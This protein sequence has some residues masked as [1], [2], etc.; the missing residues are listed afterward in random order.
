M[1]FGAVAQVPD[2]W[3]RSVYLASSNNEYATDVAVDSTNGAV[4]TAGQGES[5]FNLLGGPW[6]LIWGN[7]PTGQD[8]YLFKTDLNGN[9]IWSIA[10]GGT[11]QDACTGVCVGPN[12]NVYVCGYFSGNSASFSG[13]NGGSETLT[14]VGGRDLFLLCYDSNGVLQWKVRAGASGDD[15]ATGVACNATQVFLTGSFKGQPVIAGSNTSTGLSTTAAHGFLAAF[16]ASDSSGLWRMDCA[17]SNDAQLNAV[18]T[19]GNDVYAIGQFSG[20]SCK[21]YNTAGEAG[22]GI[23]TA[24]G[25]TDNAA[26]IA[27]T[28]VGAFQWARAVSN[29]SGGDGTFSAQAIAVSDNGLCIGGS[30]HNGSIFPGNTVIN[31]AASPHDLAYV[32]LL[33]RATGN[34]RWVRTMYSPNGNAHQQAV[35]DIVMDRQGG[36]AVTG[37]FRENLLLP[38]GSTLTG[39]NNLQVY[40]AKF[41]AWGKCKWGL[42]ATGSGDD[43]PYGIAQDGNGHLYVAGIYSGSIAFNTT[44]GGGGSSQNLFLAWLTDLDFAV[45]ALHDPSTWTGFGP[46]CANS[47]TV[48]LN[49]RLVAQ[50]AGTGVSVFA[51]SGI[52]TSGSNGPAGALGQAAGGYAT[53]DDLNDQL[54]IGL[55]DTLPAGQDLVIRWQRSGSTGTAIMSVA[56]SLAG[57]SGFTDMGNVQTSTSGAWVLTSITMTAPTRYVRLIRTTG[58]TT[59]NVD[60]IYYDLGSDPDGIWSGTGVSGSTFDPSAVNGSAAITYTVNGRSTT[61]TIAVTALPGGGTFTG[62]TAAC[63]NTSSGTLTISGHS[64]SIVRW[65]YATDGSATY[66]MIAA[67]ASSITTPV[68]TQSTRY[69][70]LLSA[71]GCNA[72]SNTASVIV[73]DITAPVIVCPGNITAHTS[74]GSCGA[75]AVYALPAATD[76]CTASPVIAN[77]DPA[78]APGSTFPIGVTT[79][80][81]RATDAAGNVGNCSFTVT[82]ID[83]IAPSITCPA[84]ITVPA[85]AGTCSVEVNYAVP[86]VSDACNG[87]APNSIAQHTYLGTFRGHTYFRSWAAAA[88]ANANTA[89]AAIANGHL[90]ALNSADEEDWLNSV[91]L[92]QTGSYAPF[93]TGLNDAAVEGTFVWA[94]GDPVSYTHWAP[95]QP[96]NYGDADYAY[97]NFNNSPGWDDAPESTNFN[98]I[99]EIDALPALVPVRL[100]GPAS[101]SLLPIGVDTVTYQV[102]DPSGNTGSCSFRITVIDTLAPTIITCPSNIQVNTDANSCGA[103]VSYRTPTAA[104]D[105]SPVTVSRTAGPVSGS[106]FPL[107]TTTVTHRAT[108]AAGNSTACSFTVT[109]A[110]A[111]PPSINCPANITVN[112]QPGLC[113][114]VVN[115]TPPIGTDNCTGAATVRTSGP[116]SG[117]VFQLGTTTVTHRVTDAAGNSTACSFTVTVIDAQPPSIN[118]PADITVNAQP[119]LCGAV[120]N[121]TPPIGTDNCTGAVTVRTSGPVSGS[122]FSVGTTTITHRVTDAAGN[123]TACSFTVTVTDAQPPSI[124]CPADITVNAQPGLCGAVVNY[125]PPIGTDNCT[126]AVTVRTAGPASGS[127][128]PTGTTTITHRVTDATGLWSECSFTVTVNDNEPPTITCPADITVNAQPGLCGA[129]VNYTPPIGTDNCTGAVTVRTSGPESGGVFQLG[130]TTV[131]HRV[132]DAAGN[133]TACSFTVTVTDAQ[134]PSINCPADVTVNA[135]PGLCGAVVSYTPPIGTDNCTGAVT[136]RTAGPASGSLFPV[137]TTTITHRVTDAAGLWSECSFTVTVNDNEPPTIICPSDITVQAEPG[138]CSAHVSYTEPVGTDNCSGA[139]TARLAGPASGSLF[140]VGTTSITYEATDVTGNQATCSFTVSVID[141]QPPTITCPNDTTVNSDPSLCGRNVIY[142]TP[143]AADN[144]SITVTTRTAGPASGSAFPIGNT[145]VTYATTDAAGTAA[146]CSFIVHVIDDLA[147]SLTCPADIVTSNAPGQCG[148]IVHYPTPVGSDNCSGWTVARIAGPASGSLFPTGTTPVVHRV[149]DAAGNSTD[150]SFTVTVNDHEPPVIT[151]PSDTTIIAA[152]GNCGAAVNYALPNA[153]DACTGPVPVSVD[154]AVSSGSIFPIGTTEVVLHAVDQAGNGASCTFH[155]EVVA[156]PIALAYPATTVCQG[157]STLLPAT[158]TPANG[159]FSAEAGLVIDPH[160]GAIAAEQS[161]A[162]TYTVHYRTDG[163]CAAEALFELTVVAAP[164]PGTDGSAAFCVNDAIGVLLDH[165]QDNPDTNGTW[166]G[167]SP[168]VDG[169]FDPASMPAGTYVYTVAGRTPCPSASASVAVTLIDVHDAAFG[170]D[171]EDHCSAEGDLTP[172]VQEPG[173]LF[174]GSIGLDIDPWTGVVRTG[175]SSIGTHTVTY[176][177]DGP[178]GDAATYTLNIHAMPVADAGADRTVCGLSTRLSASGNGSWIVP[179]GL[180]LSDVNDA[181][182]NAEAIAPGTYLLRWVVTNGPCADTA[183]VSIRFAENAIADAGPDLEVCGLAAELH[184]AGAGTWSG[185]AGTVFVDANDPLTS[186][187]VPAQGVFTLTWTTGTGSCSASDTVDVRFHAPVDAQAGPDTAWCGLTA[188]L[189][190]IGNGSWSTDAAGAHIAD[191]T[192]PNTAMTVDAEGSYPLIWTIGNGRCTVRDTV[193]IVLSSPIVAHAGTAA[194]ICGYT[195]RLD[196]QGPGHWSLTTGADIADPSD[197]HSLVTIREEGAY[198]FEW[199]TVNGSCSSSDEVTIVFHAPVN[200]EAGVNQQVCGTSAVLAASGPGT[201][202]AP[203]GVQVAQPHDPTS[204][205]NADAPGTYALVWSAVNGTCSATDTVSITF[206]ASADASF[207]Y[208]ATL[209]CSAGDDPT[210]VAAEAGGTYSATPSGLVLDAAS[211]TIDVSTSAPGS[212]TVLHDIAGQCPASSSTSITISATADASWQ[213]PGPICASADPL[214]L[215]TLLTTGLPGGVWSGTG[216]HNGTFDPEGL[217][218]LI[219]ITYSTGDGAC[220]VSVQHTITVDAAPVANAGPD[221]AVCILSSRM[222]AVPDLGSG[223]WSGPADAVFADLHDPHS[224]VTVQ[225]TGIHM[226]TWAVEAGTCRSSDQVTVRFFDPTTPLWVHAGDDQDMD[227]RIH[228]DLQGEASPGATIQWSVIG[229][230]G[231]IDHSTSPATTVHGLALG[232]NFL[233]LSASIGNCATTSDTVR[234]HVNDV[235]IPQGFSPDGDGVNE[236]FAITGVAEFPGN[237]V[238][239]FD[240]WGKRVFHAVD[241]RNEWDG[242]GENGLLP[243]GTYFYL[244]ELTPE[245]SYQGYVIIKR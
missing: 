136:V 114:A 79:I 230:N 31:V 154:A 194:E 48:D 73:Q 244:V 171:G 91:I 142:A 192:D 225:D 92:A 75:R 224:L 103:V 77:V 128:F 84:D 202:S 100:S 5:L 121:Y 184:A 195:T 88:W 220:A 62:N 70:A 169:L 89:A 19:R 74:N 166:S 233:M 183:E 188:R 98:W 37:T 139:T 143:V 23:T 67:T 4:Y 1:P 56:G 129:V 86:V 82:V 205:V 34:T 135:Q 45:A 10:L 201:W 235:F 49:T 104:D 152:A 119:G 167:P 53:F 236:T 182:A 42:A 106:V 223:T 20:T 2:G 193:I 237:I 125:M 72:Y 11:G 227:I 21:F 94:N 231:V 140:P 179:P 32:A 159:H 63:P 102:T 134:P 203:A 158:A 69:R 221:A 46:V 112:A 190:A 198:V 111:R 51:S 170:F 240:R 124:N 18:C 9:P 3:D 108:D 127:L 226:F 109:V 59:F 155:I 83:S 138:Q 25:Q 160:T 168:V 218:G 99:V 35:K 27:M 105:C 186:V 209:F 137:G 161:R 50:R 66:A 122:L 242:H 207:R 151:C 187:S 199:T 118:C 239:V 78:Q 60:G 110:D 228:A 14:S 43:A 177:I 44:L 213:A 176:A 141:A 222:E 52:S 95:S 126:G 147:P 6:A 162:G 33:A 238:E 204:A 132:T 12:G 164:H 191:P 172:T 178:C 87:S 173:G 28:T 38:N 16:K 24:A 116:E 17:S 149:T 214:E 243:D 55:A 97:M 117:G 180:T 8:G 80:H 144:C 39:S 57:A 232:D 206:I 175:T 210:P 133:S 36:I 157:A 54:T 40:L 26:V 148:A 85:P 200:V 22:T 208:D 156:A 241:Y 15:M 58:S 216:V 163:P 7:L 113:G 81:L 153:S 174:I 68:M 64:G 234:L 107:G 245:R 41:N 150:C 217:S 13:V 165:L 93:W 120:V 211:G 145:T 215:S 115:Y 229:G 181:N 219:A 65:E 123:N 96:D 30:T 130:T 146:S 71:N 61:R 29:P 189:G 212:Y 101:G 185:P 131:T 90:V 47:S 196:A 76:D 197:P